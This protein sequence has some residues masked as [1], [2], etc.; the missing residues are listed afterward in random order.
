MRRIVTSLLLLL[1]STSLTAQQI[2]DFSTNYL[3]RFN[4]IQAAEL[5]QTLETN[6]DGTRLYSS[7]MR[8]KG[9]FAYIKPDV[10]T[11]SS[12][13]HLQN[14]QIQPL[15]YSYERTGGKKRKTTHHAV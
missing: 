12:L 2:A 1:S 13:W 6:E 7:Q 8:A 15:N 10:I 4:G 14:D 11:E 5:K 9:V 3:V